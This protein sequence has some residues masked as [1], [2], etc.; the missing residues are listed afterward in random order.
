MSSENFIK[1]S[2]LLSFFS[3]SR[4]NRDHL[5]P[6]GV[7]PLGLEM[8]RYCS[9]AVPLRLDLFFL[10]SICPTMRYTFLRASFCL[11]SLASSIFFFSS[12]NT[13]CLAC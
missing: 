1:T 3:M 13:L 12:K 10:C 7:E 6:V 8:W 11:F 9:S 4:Q 5:H 2:S